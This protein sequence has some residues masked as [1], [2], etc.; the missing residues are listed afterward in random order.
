MN[1]CSL[2]VPLPGSEPYESDCGRR[3]A[4]LSLQDQCIRR[5]K[6]SPHGASIAVSEKVI[7]LENCWRARA[8][9]KKTRETGTLCL[10]PRAVTR[11]KNTGP[12]ACA[13]MLQYGSQRRD[14]VTTC[15]SESA[16]K[17][18][19]RHGGDKIAALL[20]GTYHTL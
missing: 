8:Y 14:R 20:S 18:F 15:N 5:M 13:S 2:E 1:R 4:I 7:L 3:G 12:A 17:R 6:H 10:G 16:T 9:E 11:T 19:S